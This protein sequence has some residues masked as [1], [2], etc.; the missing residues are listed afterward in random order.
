GKGAFHQAVITKSQLYRYHEGLIALSSGMYG[1]IEQFLLDH[2]YDAALQALQSFREIFRKDF[3]LELQDHHIREQKQLNLD[4]IQLSKEN[5]VP[6]VAS[7]DVH[8]INKKDAMSLDCLF[9][10]KNGD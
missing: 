6:L 3:Y 4:L 2:E 9:C 1:E 10:I 7:N 5:K 8:Y